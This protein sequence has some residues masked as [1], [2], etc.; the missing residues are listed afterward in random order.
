MPAT[1]ASGFRCVAEAIVRRWS[2]PRGGLLDDAD[3]GYD[4]T[5]RVGDDLDKADLTQMAHLAKSEAEKDERVQTCDVTLTL[6]VDGTL[7]VV[8]KVTTAAGPFNLV[9]SVSA[10]TVTLLQVTP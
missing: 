1:M 5:D 7:A 6:A 2:T 4:L 10:V 9:A 8:G 3:Y